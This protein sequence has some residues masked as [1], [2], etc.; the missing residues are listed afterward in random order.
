MTVRAEK[1]LVSMGLAVLLHP[2]FQGVAALTAKSS[3]PP[4]AWLVT[5][6]DRLPIVPAAVWLYLTWYPA[7][8]GVLIAERQ[9]FRRAYMAY[10]VA[11]AACV[12]TYLLFPVTITRPT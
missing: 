1:A 5:P 4:P 12:V 10:L 6:L 11:F 3:I 2:T 8:A 7:T 9:T